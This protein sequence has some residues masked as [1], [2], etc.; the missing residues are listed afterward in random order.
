MALK[1]VKQFQYE[2]DSWKRTLRFL[3]EENM[4]LKNRLADVVK[5]TVDE[6]LLRKAEIF[7]NR[8]LNADDLFNL[9]RSDIV[10]FDKLLAQSF[11]DSPALRIA[12][13]ECRIIRN[14]MNIVERKFTCYRRDFNNYL[15]ENFRCHDV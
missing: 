2:R 14:L 7:Q 13:G 11:Q 6:N 5:D 4:C 9:L 8:F 12:E 10:E 15:I 3:E 1:V